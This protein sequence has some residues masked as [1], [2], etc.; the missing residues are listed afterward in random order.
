MKNITYFI[1]AI[2]ILLVGVSIG[3]HFGGKSFVGA[4]SVAGT[5][6]N[7]AKVA[8]IN[9][10]LASAS[11][12]STSLLNTDDN[13]RIV[14]DAFATCSGLGTSLTAYTG[15]GLAALTI[16]AAT[17]STATLGLNAN[18]NYALNVTMAT[19]TADGYT[20][21]STYTLVASRRWAAGSYMVFFSNATNTALCSPGVHYLAQ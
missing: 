3:V 17:S 15:A 13:D 4:T 11:A 8:Q 12:T 1:V 10:S 14:T 19:A 20:A 9:L 21:T 16:Q 6:F 18:L 7:T 5:T 2:A